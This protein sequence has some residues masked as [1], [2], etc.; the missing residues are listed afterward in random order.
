M[1][2]IDEQA[3]NAE[4]VKGFQRL[5][6]LCLCIQL[7]ELNFEL[8]QIL[9]DILHRISAATAAFRAFKLCATLGDLLLNV[10]L[11]PQRA[12]RQLFKLRVGH[13][14]CVPIAVHSLREEV[15][16][17]CRL[18]VAVVRRKDFRVR[19]ESSELQRPLR[20]H[21]LR[22]HNHRFGEDAE[23][24]ALH[25]DGRDLQRFASAGR[26]RQKH[27]TAALQCALHRLGLVRLQLNT[28]GKAGRV[29]AYAVVFRVH[30]CVVRVVVD[31]A[32]R[33]FPLFV[34]PQPLRKGGLDLL[35]TCARLAC[36]VFQNLALTRDRDRL[37][38]K[39]LLIQLGEGARR[40]AGN[41]HLHVAPA[42]PALLDGKT[43]SFGIVLNVKSVR[44]FQRFIDELCVGFQ[45]N[46]RNADRGG[47]LFCRH[48][49][50]DHFSKCL[51]VALIPFVAL[52]HALC[53]PQLCTHVAGEID[54][55]RDQLAAAA[56]ERQIVVDKLRT[57]FA[58]ALS[59][60]LRNV[61]QINSGA[62]VH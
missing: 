33:D 22:Y 61:R 46:P 58:L 37:S 60:Q 3:V 41:T 40:V 1:E 4:A 47:D 10:C 19:E 52:R 26:V 14:D 2:L 49:L 27:I 59:E 25:D 18:E 42:V 34:A 45:R 35:L 55:R 24:A 32:E 44:R 17:V 36:R 23:P 57:R 9:F 31:L 62:H 54:S 8:C 30:V 21:V 7:F 50:R 48:V 38:G 20:Q 16:S 28:G 39:H 15:V 11:V 29:N 12:D 6:A 53:L 56:Q 5:L 43:L 13:N 51:H